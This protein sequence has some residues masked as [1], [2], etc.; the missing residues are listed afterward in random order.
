M[1]PEL[2]RAGPG[3]AGGKP[4]AIDGADAVFRGIDTDLEIVEDGRPVPR[5]GGGSDQ[6]ESGEGEEEG[7]LRS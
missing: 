2:E 5:R 7:R 4:Y 6:Y 1:K 3:R